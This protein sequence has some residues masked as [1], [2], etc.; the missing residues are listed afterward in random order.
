MV[1]DDCVTAPVNVDVPVTER[2]P[3]TVWFPE[4]VTLPVFVWVPV[5]VRFRTCTSVNFVLAACAGRN[6][7]PAARKASRVVFTS[8]PITA[9]L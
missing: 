9:S 2:F 3:V 4:S 1:V 8:L 6:I 5:T 7:I